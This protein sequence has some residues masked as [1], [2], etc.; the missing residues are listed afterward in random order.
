[1]EEAH[2]GEEGQRGGLGTRHWLV[3]GTVGRDMYLWKLGE[4][5]VVAHT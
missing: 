5:Q 3:G 4:D 2:T 1:M